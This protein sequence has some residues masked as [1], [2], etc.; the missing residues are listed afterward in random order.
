MKLFFIIVLWISMIHM[1]LSNTDQ[2]QNSVQ[3]LID[4]NCGAAFS[5]SDSSYCSQVD[6]IDADAILSILCSQDLI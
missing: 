2:V 4:K 3:M 5:V 6:R 1:T